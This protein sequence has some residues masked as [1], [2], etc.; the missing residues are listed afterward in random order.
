VA[1]EYPGDAATSGRYG[2]FN[3]NP[4]IIEELLNE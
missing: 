3:Y 2:F 4:R 1:G